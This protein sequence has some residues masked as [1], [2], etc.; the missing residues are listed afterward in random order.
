MIGRALEWIHQH[1]IFPTIVRARGE[2]RMFRLTRELEELQWAGLDLLQSRQRDRLASILRYA[3]N[4]SAFYRARIA[5]RLALDASTALEDIKKLPLLTKHDLQQN[6]EVVRAYPSPKRIAR[7]T[8][9]GSTGQ[10]V[11]IYKDASAIASERAFSALA[12]GWFGV[13]AGDRGARFWGTPTTFRRTL[14]SS[15]SNFAM[16]RLSFSAFSF[17]DQDLQRYWDR[18]SRFKPAYFYGYVSMLEA[19]ARFVLSRKMHPNW[20]LKLVITTS[21]V[22]TPPQRELLTKAFKVPVQNEYGCGEV[23]P[24]AYECSSGS[25]HLI[26]ENHFVEVLKDDGTDASPGETGTIVL[27]DLRNRA[28]PLIRYRV[29]DYAEVGEACACGRSFPTLRKVWGREYDVVVAPDG[30]RYH[31]EFFMYLFEDLKTRGA[32]IEKFQV[33]QLDAHRLE[34]RIIAHDQDQG[35]E[36]TIERELATRLPD[37]RAVVIRVE[38]IPPQLSGKSLVVENRWKHAG[39]KTDSIDL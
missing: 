5:D 36:A 14:M 38:N 16:N 21:E 34:V 2:H 7:K 19:L 6:S 24:I 17:T 8:T 23:G 25:L 26:T 9:G 15:A 37:M 32:G 33:I 30:R 10:P 27:T 28:M 3:S 13:K 4:H 20:R 31:G 11:V 39:Q 35:I 29:G 22:L 18:C 12:Y 1:F